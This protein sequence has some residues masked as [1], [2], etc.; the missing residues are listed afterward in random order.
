M[1]GGNS[2]NTNDETPYACVDD[3]PKEDPGASLNEQDHVPV[4]DNIFKMDAVR[5]ELPLN[6][7][8]SKHVDQGKSTTK[9]VKNSRKLKDYPEKI[10]T[11]NGYL[12][13]APRSNVRTML[14]ASFKA[15]RRKQ[16]EA[17]KQQNE[18]SEPAALV[19]TAALPS[20][21]ASA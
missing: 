5:A 21:S 13:Y 15:Y 14:R 17:L 11:S 8:K 6:L 20:P 4:D 1:D 10:R 18:S 12:F 3:I 19:V 2:K 7:D 16:I 9:R